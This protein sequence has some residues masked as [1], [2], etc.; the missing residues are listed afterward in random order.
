MSSWF[1]ESRV[2][3]TGIFAYCVFCPFAAHFYRIPL[4]FFF[5]VY[6]NRIQVLSQGTTTNLRASLSNSKSSIYHEN[7]VI[8]DVL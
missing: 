4:F 5:L 2:V 3:Y 8:N 1:R 6:P 7:S